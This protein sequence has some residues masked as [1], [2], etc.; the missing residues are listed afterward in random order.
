MTSA[1][2]D[3]QEHISFPETLSTQLPSI[4]I[5]ACLFAIAIAISSYASRFGVIAPLACT[6]HISLV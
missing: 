4:S 6:K 1:T 2:V 3:S 5:C